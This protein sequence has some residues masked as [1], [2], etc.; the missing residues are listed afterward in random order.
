MN[1]DVLTAILLTP[2]L[3]ISIGIVLWLGYRKPKPRPQQSLVLAA[4]SQVIY[5]KF[6]TVCGHVGFPIFQQK[7]SSGI[8]ILLWLTF[9]V[10]GIIYSVWRSSTKQWVCGSC[11]NAAVIPLDSPIAKRIRATLDKE[12][13]NA[14]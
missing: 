13:K 2:V 3:L 9:I 11:G 7:G 4:P 6:C 5:A 14:S 12:V 10:P 8:E 1:P